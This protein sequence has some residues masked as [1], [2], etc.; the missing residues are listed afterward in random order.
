MGVVFP[1]VFLNLYC[2]P[3]TKS[4][5]LLNLGHQLPSSSSSSLS[6]SSSNSSP[7]TS[8]SLS[9]VISSTGSSTTG[10][11]GVSGEASGSEGI[12][13]ADED[14]SKS[15]VGSILNILPCP[16]DTTYI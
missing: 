6:S 5:S 4:E 16:R 9:S 11:E 14:I 7:V 10:G 15:A 8:S 13:P 2:R 3:I 1:A 12:F